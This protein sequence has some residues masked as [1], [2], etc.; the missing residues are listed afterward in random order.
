MGKE[1]EEEEEKEKKKERKKLNPKFIVVPELPNQPVNRIIG[2]D[3]KEYL[4]ITRDEA[5]A[6]ILEKVRKLDKLL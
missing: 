4:L 5:I 6:E 3:G 2:E 1:D